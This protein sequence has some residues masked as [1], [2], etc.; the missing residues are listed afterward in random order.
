MS[1]SRSIGPKQVRTAE[2][3]SLHISLWAQRAHSMLLEAER[4]ESGE[5]PEEVLELLE[6][7]ERSA[8]RLRERLTKTTKTVEA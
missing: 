5:Y 3:E 8:K 6:V 1:T 7:V 4:T 2:D